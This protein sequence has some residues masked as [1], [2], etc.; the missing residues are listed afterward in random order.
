MTVTATA[1]VASG[2]SACS[3]TNVSVRVPALAP[4]SSRDACAVRLRTT[5]NPTLQQREHAAARGGHAQ[6][7]G[8]TGLQP[9]GSALPALPGFIVGFLTILLQIPAMSDDL[10]V[11]CACTPH[12]IPLLTICARPRQ[13]RFEAAAQKVRDFDPS[14]P[15]SNDEKLRAYGLYK[16]ATVGDVEGDR[17]GIFNMTARAKYDAWAAQKG[18]RAL[19]R[20]AAA[21]C[22]SDRA[23]GMRAPGMRAPGKSKEQAMQEYIEEVEKQMREHA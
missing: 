11:H 21:L 9:I 22:R 20:S 19:A 4:C 6:S 7:C 16:Q 10:T 5:P 2:H 18:A 1:A 12:E 14:T 23:L 13:T 8:L 17:P 15:V 3:V